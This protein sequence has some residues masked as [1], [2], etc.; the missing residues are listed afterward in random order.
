MIGQKSD[1]ADM[2]M[3]AEGRSQKDL[4]IFRNPKNDS[5]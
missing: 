3:M 5:V 1:P 4:T 2:G